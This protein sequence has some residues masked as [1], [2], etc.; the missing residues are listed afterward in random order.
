M[1]IMQIYTFLS[2]SFLFMK[3][4]PESTWHSISSLAVCCRHICMQMPN[5]GSSWFFRFICLCFIN[6]FLFYLIL[7]I[8][9]NRGV[10][11][12]RLKLR[13]L[14]LTSLVCH[15]P[16]ASRLLNRFNANLCN[17]RA[18]FLVRSLSLLWSQ[19]SRCVVT[20]FQNKL[21]KIKQI[22]VIN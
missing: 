22:F 10:S 6:F 19:H 14:S 12:L 5:G 13:P 3:M 8:F 21:F 17:F 15:T 2:I 1:Q 4:L 18:A 7:F 11:L 9:F 16:F 20:Q